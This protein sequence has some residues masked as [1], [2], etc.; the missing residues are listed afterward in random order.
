M[1]FSKRTEKEIRI[2]DLK[3]GDV[4][5][6]AE[7]EYSFIRIKRGGESMVVTQLSNE[8]NYRLVIRD[9]FSTKTVIGKAKTKKKVVD[10]NTS[11]VLLIKDVKLNESVVIMTG[12]NNQVPQL[13]KLVEIN[14]ANKFSYVFMNP[15]TRRKEKFNSNDSWKVYRLDD[16]K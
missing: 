15:V 2:I 14:V 10:K 7:K 9:I 11:N 13:Y 1:V 8:K 4:F 16:L 3:E 5:I 6:V 12:R